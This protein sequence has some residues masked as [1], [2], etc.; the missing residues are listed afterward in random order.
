VDDQVVARRSGLKA[1][2]PGVGAEGVHIGNAPGSAGH[3]LEGDIDEVKIWRLDP[4]AMKKAFLARP[5]DQGSADCWARFFRRL[6]E[7]L[8]KHPECA[9]ELAVSLPAAMDDLHRAIVQSSPSA[10]ETFDELRAEYARLWRRGSL[11]SA[12]MAEVFGGINE[13]LPSGAPAEDFP[14]LRAVLDSPCMQ[15]LREEL[16]GFDVDCDPGVAAL[17]AR[18]ARAPGASNATSA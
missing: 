1:A 4:E 2:I 14:P 17:G 7:V 15:L 10:R 3:C 9:R 5:W 6:R 18:I 16:K 12:A 13:L 11:G 8:S